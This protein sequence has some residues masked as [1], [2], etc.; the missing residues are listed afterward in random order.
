MSR[1]GGRPSLPIW[2]QFD[3]IIENGVIKAKCRECGYV[4]SNNAHRM[5]RHYI[6]QHT[7]SSCSIDK[8]DDEEISSQNESNLSEEQPVSL[9]K[10]VNDSASSTSSQTTT[11]K[12]AEKS[13]T[14]KKS[15]P[16]FS[17]TSHV[18]RTSTTEKHQIDI[19][20]AKIFYAANFPISITENPAFK[21]F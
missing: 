3:K 10:S 8:S 11:V 18:V 9:E 7:A 13:K 21:V 19:K 16:K 4:L 14:D 20:C 6:S 15:N 5:N 17:L 1:A 12:S 2:D